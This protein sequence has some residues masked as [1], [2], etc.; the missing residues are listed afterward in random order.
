M[1]KKFQLPNHTDARFSLTPVELK[2]Y[3]DFEAKRIYYVTAFQ[4]PTGAHCHKIEKEFF[5]CVQG[6]ITA[7]I[8]EGKGLQ[9]YRL[10]KDEAI[11]VD[12]YIWHQ[13]K[14]ASADAVLLAIS[15]TNYNPQR[16]DYIENYEEFQKEIY[17]K[18]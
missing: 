2:D 14:D 8:D 15:S 10:H 5:I 7:V 17:V 13:F 6:E 4:Q 18:K 11:Y 16:E 12:N 9:E 3:L 1:F